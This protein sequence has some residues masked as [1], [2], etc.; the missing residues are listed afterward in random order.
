[1]N[2]SFFDDP[3]TLAHTLPPIADILWDTSDY[4]DE[5]TDE[6]SI[7]AES[8]F[9]EDEDAHVRFVGYETILVRQWL[10]RLLC[11]LSCGVLGLLG[12]W[13]PRLWLGWVT[14]EKSFK[15]LKHGFIVI[16]V[17]EIICF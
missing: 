12:H 1:M 15:D 17:S 2:T 4:Y 6:D 14:K 7:S 11:V 16:E 9:I 5:A 3:S 13:F 10:W 8:I